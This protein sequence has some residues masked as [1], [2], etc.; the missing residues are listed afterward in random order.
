MIPQVPFTSIILLGNPNTGKTTIFNGLTGLH[1][2]TGNW[3]GS[4]VSQTQGSFTMH[5]IFH[6]PGRLP[7]VP[8]WQK[9]NMIF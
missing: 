6:L 8:P 1:C 9:T 5:R 2:H 3:P 7:Y 4:T